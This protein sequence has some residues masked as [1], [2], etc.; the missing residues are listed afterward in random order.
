MTPPREDAA[1]AVSKPWGRVGMG[2]GHREDTSFSLPALLGG[3][4]VF[5][6]LLQGQY[7]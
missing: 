1:C 7:A 6:A 5:Q 3:A 4:A 2:G